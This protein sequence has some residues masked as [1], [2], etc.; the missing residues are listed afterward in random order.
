MILWK[1]HCMEDTY[2]GMWPRWFLNQCVGVGWWSGW[3]FSLTVIPI[4]KIGLGLETL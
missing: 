4:I 3:G 1:F 2:P